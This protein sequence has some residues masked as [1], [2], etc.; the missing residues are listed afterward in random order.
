MLEDT[1]L[2]ERI[3]VARDVCHGKPRVAGTR[4]MV[5][6]VLDLLAAGKTIDAITSAD[7]YPDLVPADV[8]ACVDYASRVVSSEDIV[9]L[10]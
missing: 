9:P 6:Q 10:S 5:V 8:L 7:Y 1:Y 3:V 4:I 2:T